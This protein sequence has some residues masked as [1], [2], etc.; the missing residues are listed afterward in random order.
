MKKGICCDDC[1]KYISNKSS[2]N[3]T[4][5]HKLLSLSV[6]NR[7]YIKTIQVETIEYVI[8]EH[9]IDYNKKFFYFRGYVAFR[10]DYFC[11]KIDIGWLN[12]P[13][14]V[15][16]DEILKRYKCNKKELVELK[17]MFIT[18]SE[19]QSYNHYLQQPRPMVERQICKI[20]GRNSNLIK[21]VDKMPTPYS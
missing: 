18:G 17:V 8:K 10:I 9:I 5:T 3:K 11:S 20:I 1:D 21:T 16:S 15:I 13:F 19:Y 2:H 6:F 14:V 12:L 4:K 7:F